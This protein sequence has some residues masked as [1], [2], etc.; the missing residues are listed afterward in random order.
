MAIWMP[1]VEEKPGL[2][3]WPPPLTFRKGCLYKLILVRIDM[4]YGLTAN[5]V[6]VVPR[7]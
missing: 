6:R 2:A 1:F 4:G 5:G 7:T 3:V